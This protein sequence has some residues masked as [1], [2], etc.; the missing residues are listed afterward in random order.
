MVDDKDIEGVF[1][2]LP[3]EAT[4]YFAKAD[5]KRAV[6]ETV[7]QIIGEQHGLNG[8]AYPTVKEAYKS[9]MKEAETDDF[10]FIGG[11]TYVV[12]DLLKNGI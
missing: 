9:A 12:A 10:V 4:Y 2:L 6:S 5:N 1:N 8:G 7:L 11:S 3:K